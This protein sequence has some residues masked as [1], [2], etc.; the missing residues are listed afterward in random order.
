MPAIPETK[1]DMFGDDITERDDTP[2]ELRIRNL[3]P[4]P[5]I[6]HVI[7]R[8]CATCYYGR[9]NNGSFECLRSDGYQCDAGD[10]K[11]WFHVCK[12]YKR[13]MN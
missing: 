1:R 12:F 7:P 6:H 2:E 9:I 11:Q 3:L 5:E 4:V 10:G 13:E 8:I